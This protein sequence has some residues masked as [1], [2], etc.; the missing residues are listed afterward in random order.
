[1]ADPKPSILLPTL[2]IAAIVV[3]AG[4]GTYFLYEANHPKLSTVWTVSVGSNVTVNYI[5]IFGSGPQ[6][7]KVFDTSLWSVYVNNGS[8]P[9]SLEFDHGLS[10]KNYTPLGVSVGPNIPSGGYTID[11]ITFGSVVTGFWQGLIGLAVG[12]TRTISIPPAL[13]YGPASAS[14]FVTAPLVVTVPTLVTLTP[15]AFATAYPGINATGGTHF[16]DPT[17]GWPAVVFSVNSSA[18]VVENLPTLSWSVPGTSWPVVVTGVNATSITLRNELSYGDIG[19]VL[20]HVS[21]SGTC[22]SNRYVVTGLDP[23][24]GTFTQDYNSEVAG[25]TL[26]FTVTV[27]ASY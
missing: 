14:C 20:G 8:F 3:G 11:N 9:K 22:G 4:V 27:V 24:A 21:G 2:L 26:N 17:Y 13:A 15:S 23:G 5:G 25:E 19:N 1:M 12:Q 18:V 16:A 7:G 6:M 10:P